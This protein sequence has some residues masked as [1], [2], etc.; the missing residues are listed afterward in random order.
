MKLVEGKNVGVMFRVNQAT[1]L[2]RDGDYYLVKL[3]TDSLTIKDN[4]G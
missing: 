2:T 1:S 4:E 3:K